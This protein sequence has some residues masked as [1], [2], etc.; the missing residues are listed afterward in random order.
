MTK[1][2][3]R[4]I[5]NSYLSYILKIAHMKYPEI[6]KRQYELKYYLD[7]FVLILNDLVKWDSLNLLKDYPV[8]S[9]YHWKAIQN[10][11]NKWS[12][13]N[14]FEEALNMFMKEN[15][16]KLRDVKRS[17]KLNLF[18]D[19]TYICNKYGSQLIAKNPEYKK[20]NMT[21]LSVVCDE[22][23][24]PIGVTA[25][26][27]CQDKYVIN[28]NT[29]NE[30]HIRTHKHDSKTVQETLDKVVIDIPNYVKCKLIGDKG[31]ITKNEFKINNKPIK[32]IAPKRKNQKTKN[33]KIEKKLLS[34]RHK[35]ENYFCFLKKYERICLRK[36][37]NIN[38]FMSF[39]YLALLKNLV[40]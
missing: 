21:K 20:K 30:Q 12:K 2:S 3:C 22:Y 6:R 28:R 18:I 38:T 34:M 24:Y 26:S 32:I 36:D 29:F 35:V 14:V 19:S 15:Y 16:F 4:K 10:E 37:R 25:V 11:F 5:D 9:P 40:K 33:T 23:K 7:K 13:D 17:K 1:K 8:D 31:Y 39:V 27:L